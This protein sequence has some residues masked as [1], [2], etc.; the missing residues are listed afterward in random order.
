M[1]WLGFAPRS[2]PM[3]QKANGK[4]Q[5]GEEQ[6]LIVWVRLSNDDSGTE[7]ERE[8]LFKLEDELIP[9]IEKSGAGEY[10]G[11]EIGGG[12]FTLYMYGS[13][14]SRL[15]EAISPTLKRFQVPSGSYA[16]KRYGK[17]GAKE[18]RVAL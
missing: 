17:P 9:L 15:W 13:S 6:A 3:G 4:A 10:D 7:Q 5:D 2:E 16:I 12:F 1:L 8:K 11:N 18:E 14:A